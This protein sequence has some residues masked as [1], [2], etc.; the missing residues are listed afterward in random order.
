ME[1]P[2]WRVNPSTAA[3]GRRVRGDQVVG[4]A[5]PFIETDI[6][7][8]LD[9]LPRSRLHWLVAVA[10]CVAWILH[11]LE[12]TLA[13]SVA[14]ALQEKPTLRFCPPRAGVSASP[15]LLGAHPVTS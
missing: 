13:G 3:K 8:R 7:A 14:G 6:P 10:L 15:Y 2:A 11:W 5:S 12:V 1:K 4:Q 9:R